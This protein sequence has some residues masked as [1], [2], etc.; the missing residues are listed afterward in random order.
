MRAVDRIRAEVA[1]ASERDRRLTADI[2]ALLASTNND[3]VC[4]FY[5]DQAAEIMSLVR[6][7]DAAHRTIQHQEA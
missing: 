5:E 4:R 3:D 7:S 1:A 2:A 6:Q